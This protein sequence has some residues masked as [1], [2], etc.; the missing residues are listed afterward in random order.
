MD[1]DAP[2]GA[3]A[4]TRLG[5][6]LT[7]GTPYLA[8][9]TGLGGLLVVLAYAIGGWQIIQTSTDVVG[10]GFSWLRPASWAVAMLQTGNLVVDI[11]GLA[12][13]LYAAYGV[14]GQSALIPAFAGGLA[15][16]TMNTG[17]LGGLAAGVLAGAVTRALE[18]ITVPARWRAVTAKAVIPLITTLATAVVF[19]SALVNP[20]LAHLNSWMYGHLVALEVT[21]HH[22]LLGLVLGLAVCCDLG[23]AVYKIAYGYALAGIQSYS[24]IPAHT[25]FM[26]VV[27]AA[28][29]VPPVG[30]SLATVIRRKLFTP[31]ERSYGKVAWLP[32]LAF[33]PEAA[34]PFA[35]RD[36]LR[37]IP[38]SM[39]GG[40]VT[41]LLITTFGST[42]PVPHGGFFAAD[43]LGKPLLFAVAVAA[44]ALV[45]AGVAVALK[46]LRRTEIPV[47]TGTAGST[48][49]TVAVAG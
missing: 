37:V 26:A 44:G 28:G 39:A 29:M 47:S 30:L 18:R 7:D 10:Q 1:Q 21:D 33:V 46:S 38:A 15:A 25:S 32:G 12:V 31:A 2:P 48:R 40:A 35:L 23:G 3:R 17:Y 4:V 36:P 34:V 45:T 8:I 9:L 14:A 24:P 11:L 22:L 20:Q 41:G 42:I 19:F 43:Q 49:P 5:R 6:W 27:M 16:V 13:A